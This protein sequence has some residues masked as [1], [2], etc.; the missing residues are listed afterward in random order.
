MTISAVQL[1]TAMGLSFALIVVIIACANFIQWYGRKRA[2]QRAASQFPSPEDFIVPP[3]HFIL[4]RVLLDKN[5]HASLSTFQLLMWTLLISFLYVTLWFL[6]LR[7]GSTQAPPAIPEGLM[8]LMGISV[9]VPIV[10]KGISEYKKLKA[11]SEGKV[12]SEPRYASMLEEDGQPSLLRFQMF[13]WTI[14]AVVIY[15][16]LFITAVFSAGPEAVS[17]GL[18]DIDPTLLFLMGLSQ[19]GYLGSAAYAGTLEKSGA[20]TMNPPERI[21]A[22]ESVLTAAT[23]AIRE[24]IPRSAGS[25]ELVTLLGSGFGTKPD[26]LMIGQTNVS[27][28]YI[29]RWEE[30]RIEFILPGTVSPGRHALVVTAEGNSARGE[31]TVSTPAWVHE[32]IEKTAADI[33]SEIWI[34]D[35]SQ[36][37]YRVPPIGYFIPD[38]RYYFFFEFAVPPGTP[39]WGRTEFQAGFYIDGKPVCEP[40]SF[41]PGYMNGKNYGVFDY[42]FESEGTFTIEI[43]GATAKTMNIIVKRPPGVTG[44]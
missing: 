25:K 11:R 29:R 9:G 16:W 12:Y 33:I 2:A 26:S 43:R 6:Q 7:D 23:P 15:F 34:D 35:P 8:A 19:A 30:G 27:P 31:I 39:S 38:K 40:R 13:L 37:G 42:R 32:G 44:G 17:V 18:P 21:P 5:G 3:K 22:T 10:S 36:K 41:M 1:A 20:V 28:E 24:T 4:L 14:A